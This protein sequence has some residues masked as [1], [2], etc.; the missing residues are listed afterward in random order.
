MKKLLYFLFAVA[1]TLTLAFS[2][3]ACNRNFEGDVNVYMP[4]GAP[5]LAFSKLMHDENKLGKNEKLTYTVVPAASISTVVANETAEIAL[6]PVNAAVKLA[7]TGE[8]Y[9][10]AAVL[11]HGN[12]FVIGTQEANDVNALK[13]KTIAVANLAN[14]PGL[15]LKAILKSNDVAFTTDED[16]KTSENVLL[17]D[18]GS[19]QTAAPAA[20]AR[21]KQGLA[22]FALVPEPA[23][24]N[25]SNAQ[26][27][28]IRLSLQTLWGESGFPQAALLIKNELAEDKKFI[29][30]LLD[31][32]TESATWV[33]TH[34]SEAVA[35][36]SAHFIEGQATTLN[37]A[38][39]SETAIN[40][41]SIRVK[42]AKDIKSA[43]VDYMTKINEVGAA[44]FG[45][46]SDA[47]FL[48]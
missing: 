31:A 43:V 15:T 40:N 38:A 32:L 34:A 44:S 21:V 30:N 33:S 39:L 4:D 45:T 3:T 10:L 25:L 9:K 41:S 18:T 1:L 48:D 8:K 35:A 11:T 19:D 2:L 20:A 36:I 29:K 47:F 22:D 17:V 42:K 46:P 5:A 12:L 37:A 26:G 23:A 14:V 7:G 13:G 27:F 16:A 6:L 24:T 28:S